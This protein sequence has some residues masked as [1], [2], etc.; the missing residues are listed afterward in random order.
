MNWESKTEH[1][2]VYEKY[3][4][5]SALTLDGVKCS[6][7]KKEKEMRLIGGGT[8]G[9]CKQMCEDDYGKRLRL[10]K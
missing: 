2:L 1:H 7:W 8:M 10:V 6:A 5:I 3:S 9:E 4:I